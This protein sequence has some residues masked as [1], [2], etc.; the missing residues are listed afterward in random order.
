MVLIV[1]LHMMRSPRYHFSQEYVRKYAEVNPPSEPVGDF[2]DR[3]A[4]YAM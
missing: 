4:L 3:N 1:E 2:D